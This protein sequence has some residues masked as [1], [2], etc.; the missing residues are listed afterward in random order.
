MSKGIKL[1]SLRF[2]L[3]A[4]AGDVEVVAYKGLLGVLVAKDH[5]VFLHILDLGIL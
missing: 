3:G 2:S 1:S 4:W 5:L